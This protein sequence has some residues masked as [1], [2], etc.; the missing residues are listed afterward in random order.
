MVDPGACRDLVAS[1]AEG[2]PRHVQPDPRTAFRVPRSS[3]RS[4]SRRCRS[5]LAGRLPTA[6]GFGRLRPVEEPVA[7]TGLRAVLEA[8]VGAGAVDTVVHCCASDVPVAALV[9]AGAER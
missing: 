6:S 1:L 5:V 3:S 7:V 4:T 8:A 9:R 2:V